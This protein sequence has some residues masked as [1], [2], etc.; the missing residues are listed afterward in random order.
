MRENSYHSQAGTLEDATR[1]VFVAR[2]QLPHH[3]RRRH[4]RRL[5]LRRAILCG[6]KSHSGSSKAVEKQNEPANQTGRCCRRRRPTKPNKPNITSVSSAS[7]S[8]PASVLYLFMFY[9]PTTIWHL[10]PLISY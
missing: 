9:I 7:P 6:P 2:R 10:K 3:Y 1:A 8:P 4:R 5:A